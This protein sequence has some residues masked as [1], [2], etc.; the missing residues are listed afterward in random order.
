MRINNDDYVLLQK[1]GKRQTNDTL[2]TAIEV[3]LH[4]DVTVDVI[5]NRFETLSKM[6]SNLVKNAANATSLL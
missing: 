5:T 6:L 1:A 2:S 4:T 3:I